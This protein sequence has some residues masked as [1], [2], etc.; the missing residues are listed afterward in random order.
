ML[1]RGKPAFLLGAGL[2]PGLK[3]GMEVTCIS[4]RNT[5]KSR[6]HPLATLVPL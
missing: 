5:E 3:V 1:A 2:E 6:L 4:I